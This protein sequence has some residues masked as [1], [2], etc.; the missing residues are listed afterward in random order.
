[1]LKK[2]LLLLLL[3]LII[4]QF[5]HPRRNKTAGAQPNYIG[6]I[7]PVPDSVRS[8]LTKACNDCH[9]NNTRYPWYSY[10][11]PLHWWLDKHVREGKSH[12]NLDEYNHRPLRYRYH[13]MEEIVEQVDEKHMPITSYTWTHYDARLSPEERAGLV[14]WAK[15]V[16]DTM[17]ARYPI[18]SLIRTK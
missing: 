14:G 18:D 5:I 10:I 17:K 6:N 7:H 16:M 1:M 12:L 15:S 8:V 4:I 2:I 13:K 9:S 3:G 11:Q